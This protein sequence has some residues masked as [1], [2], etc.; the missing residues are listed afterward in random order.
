MGKQKYNHD[1]LEDLNVKIANTIA[2]EERLKCHVMKKFCSQNGS[3]SVSEMLKVKKKLWPNKASSLP[4]PK[5][6]HNGMFVSTTSEINK[7]MKK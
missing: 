5:L 2:L 1:V 7:T 6:N 3:L 4:T